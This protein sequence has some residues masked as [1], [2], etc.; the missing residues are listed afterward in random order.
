MQDNRI[1]E[2]PAAT[3]GTRPLLQRYVVLVGYCC[4]HSGEQVVW[5]ESE[6]AAV[7]IG[8]RLKRISCRY[9]RRRLI[10]PEGGAHG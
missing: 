8:T 2:R 9:C 6:T 4:G 1:V 7:A 10:E 3:S 5:A